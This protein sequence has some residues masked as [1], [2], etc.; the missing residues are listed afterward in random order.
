MI[1]L[2]S[3][4]KQNFQVE[5]AVAQ[6]SILLKNLLEDVGESEGPIPL[7]N[8]SSKI[9]EKV[10]AYCKHHKDDPVFVVDEDKDLFDSNRKRPEE[11]DEWDAGF[12]KGINI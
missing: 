12:I 9:L 3:Q 2:T 1:T 10:L 4:D 5:L 11:I 7:P 8:V 6:R